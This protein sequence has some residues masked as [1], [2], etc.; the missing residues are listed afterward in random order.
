MTFNLHVILPHLIVTL[1]ATLNFG[2]S[3]MNENMFVHNDGSGPTLSSV[4]GANLGYTLVCGLCV[5]VCVCVY[6]SV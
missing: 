3:L 5:C 2:A 4:V 6:V 1:N